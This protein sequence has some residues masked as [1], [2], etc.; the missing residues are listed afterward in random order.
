M[1]LEHAN[2]Y[3][4]TTWTLRMP[5]VMRSKAA[6]EH[7]KISEAAKSINNPFT[8]LPSTELVIHADET[9]T[10]RI[11]TIFTWKGIILEERGRPL[12]LE[13]RLFVFEF[14]W[15]SCCAVTVSS[16]CLHD[17]LLRDVLSLRG[18]AREN[19]FWWSLFSFLSFVF[20]FLL[21]FFVLPFLLLF[22]FY[23]ANEYGTTGDFGFP[24]LYFPL[25][26]VMD[27]QAG[28]R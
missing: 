24:S 11:S 8:R 6:I 12:E 7:S 13:F 10:A 22:T 3:A 9:S 2:R 23:E 20:T 26:W 4:E 14:W 16:K 19:W 15:G 5:F 28:Q 17:Y 21:F 1:E 25:G 27:F 18:V